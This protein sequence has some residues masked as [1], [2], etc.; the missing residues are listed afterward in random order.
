MVTI[1]EEE[2]AN[3]VLTPEQKAR[4]DALAMMPD[5][6]IDYSDIPKMTERDFATMVRVRDYPTPQEARRVASELARMEREGKSIQE[7]KAYRASTIQ[8][9]ANV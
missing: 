6:E 8:R 7:L 4:L 5:E 1:T 3:L 2:L 9:P